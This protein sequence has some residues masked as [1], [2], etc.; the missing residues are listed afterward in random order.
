MALQT[1]PP[2]RT[3]LQTAPK[4]LGFFWGF[5]NAG[6]L[7]I[8]EGGCR[9]QLSREHLCFSVS[10]FHH[11][12]TLQPVW[13][14]I[15][16]LQHCQ[17]MLATGRGTF[18]CATQSQCQLL[19]HA[20]PPCAFPFPCTLTAPPSFPPT[21]LPFPLASPPGPYISTA[22]PLGRCSPPARKLLWPSCRLHQRWAHSAESP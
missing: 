3:A 15:R 13:K 9:E 11:S 22:L 18:I 12:I 16:I 2:E 5:G 17:V 7:G 4:S 8:G 19:V 21:G 10:L 20:T 14:Q 6:K 1:P